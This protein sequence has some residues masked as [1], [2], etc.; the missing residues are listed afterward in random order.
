[1]GE[2]ERQEAVPAEEQPRHHEEE[3]Q[4]EERFRSIPMREASTCSL[5]SEASSQPNPFF[6][7]RQLGTDA[8][9]T[10]LESSSVWSSAP[11]S[12]ALS[13]LDGFMAMRVCELPRDYSASNLSEA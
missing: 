11:A 2:E 10:F 7:V 3:E 13:S 8:T 4:G 1:M 12:P 5:W 9:P 6:A